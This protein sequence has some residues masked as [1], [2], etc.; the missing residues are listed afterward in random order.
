MIDTL[1]ALDAWVLT[2]HWHFLLGHWGIYFSRLILHF[3]DFDFSFIFMRGT[4]YCFEYLA[5]T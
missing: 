2:I 1:S 3:F 5:Y 4:E